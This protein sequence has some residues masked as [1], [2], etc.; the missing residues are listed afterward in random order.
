MTSSKC[1]VALRLAVF[2]AV[3]C[4]LRVQK[5]CDCADGTRHADERRP[6]NFKM[7]SILFSREGRNGREED[8][9]HVRE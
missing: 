9:N 2:S 7:K 8:P 4:F 5:V 3:L 6:Y 1:T